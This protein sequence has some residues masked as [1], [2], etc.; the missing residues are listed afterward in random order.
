MGG[1]LLHSLSVND[2]QAVIPHKFGIK[3]DL[4]CFLYI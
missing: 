2:N 1:Q 4:L 3:H